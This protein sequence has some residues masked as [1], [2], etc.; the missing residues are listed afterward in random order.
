MDYTGEQ[1]YILIVDPETKKLK[2]ISENLPF[3]SNIKSKYCPNGLCLWWWRITMDA[4]KTKMV[5]HWYSESYGWLSAYEMQCA[6][7]L[8]KKNYPELTF[9]TW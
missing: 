2:F 7:K 9:V 5:L 6:I 8:L 3:H 1:K 4:D